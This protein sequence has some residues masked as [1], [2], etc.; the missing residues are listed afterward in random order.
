VTLTPGPSP[1]GRGETEGGRNLTQELFGL[2]QDQLI[3]EA[4][5]L[6]AKRAKHR[7]TDC[8]FRRHFRRFVNPPVQFDVEAVFRAEEVRD[9]IVDLVLASKPQS[10]YEKSLSL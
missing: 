5:H 2:F 1:R 9:V 7:V 8:I 4:Q 3:G 10:V 6:E